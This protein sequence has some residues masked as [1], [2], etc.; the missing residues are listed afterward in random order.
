MFTKLIRIDDCLP[1]CGVFVH[2]GDK[3]LAVFHLSDPD[4]FVVSQNTCPHAGGNLSAGEISGHC[5]TCPMHN[6]KFDLHTGYCVGTD[7]VIIKRYESKVRDGALF[8]D[9]SSPLPVPP[10]PKYD[11]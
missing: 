7:D 6:W 2:R 11:F 10:P 9:L 1:G 4:H 5:V 3:E 8:A